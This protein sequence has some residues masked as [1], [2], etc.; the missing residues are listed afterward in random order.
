ML[1]LTWLYSLC[2]NKCSP[3]YLPV[4]YVCLCCFFSSLQWAFMEQ[5]HKGLY[6]LGTGTGVYFK[7]TSCSG[8]FLLELALNAGGDVKSFTTFEWFFLVIFFFCTSLRRRFI[9]FSILLLLWTALVS[10]L[11]CRAQLIFCRL[12]LYS[13]PGKFVC[14]AIQSFNKPSCSPSF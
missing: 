14:C 12:S 4:G 9:L 11:K 6:F 13:L 10:F 3:R 1:S 7:N 5:A 2:W 8:W